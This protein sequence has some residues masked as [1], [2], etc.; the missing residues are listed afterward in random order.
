M[1]PSYFALTVILG[2]LTLAS[3]SS[4]K[5]VKD[6][7]LASPKLVMSKGACFGE[8][9]VYTLTIYNTGLMKYNGVRFTKMDGKYEKQLTEPEY[10]SLFSFIE[11]KNIW[12]LDDVYN[13]DI[14]DLPALSLSYSERE[15]TKTIKG[16][17]ELPLALTEIQQYLDTL[18]AG[19]GWILTEAPVEKPN[20]E[21][22]LIKDEIIIKGNSKL[23][24]VRWLKKYESYGM[25]IG[26]RL[27]PESDYWLLRF[28]TS[29]IEPEK[30]LEMI[31]KDPAIEVAEFNKKIVT[32]D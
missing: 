20:E 15:N 21:S 25:R 31:Q 24:L 27:G 6:P 12:K 5:M 32:R 22:V 8:C 23:I 9:P 30:M 13:M 11:E 14:A 1:I 3:C 29:T 7:A 28:D 16:K 26:K 10:I 2:F 19:D 18:I 17:S 4:I